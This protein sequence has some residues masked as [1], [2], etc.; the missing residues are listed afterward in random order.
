MCQM[1]KY[2][3]NIEKRIALESRRHSQISVAFANKSLCVNL[4]YSRSCALALDSAEEK[5]APYRLRWSG[6]QS[7]PICEWDEQKTRESSYIS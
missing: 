1:F 2:A 7:G 4:T 6:L 3:Q 5:F